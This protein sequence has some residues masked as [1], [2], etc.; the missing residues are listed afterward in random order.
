MLFYI[1]HI[2][3]HDHKC[4]PPIL[5]SSQFMAKGV[6]TTDNTS[7]MEILIVN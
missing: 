4:P 7:E 2:I 3:T 1:S 6:A 5:Y